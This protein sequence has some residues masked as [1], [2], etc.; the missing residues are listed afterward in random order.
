MPDYAQFDI[1]DF[2]DILSRCFLKIRYY[3]YIDKFD[4]DMFS[5]DNDVEFKKITHNRYCN[6]KLYEYEIND[7]NTFYEIKLN[8]GALEKKFMKISDIYAIVM[9]TN[10]MYKIKFNRIK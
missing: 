1:C 3:I 9:S 6:I 5:G 8:E 10:N 2:F 7:E 4:Y